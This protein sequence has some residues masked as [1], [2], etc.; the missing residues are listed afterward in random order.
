ML[1]TSAWRWWPTIPAAWFM[2]N[3]LR[4]L[5]KL[6][7]NLNKILCFYALMYKYQLHL[8]FRYAVLDYGTNY[9]NLRNIVDGA[10]W[11]VQ[12]GFGAKLSSNELHCQDLSRPRLHGDNLGQGVHAVLHAGLRQI[13]NCNRISTL[14]IINWIL[15]NCQLKV[16]NCF[17]SKFPVET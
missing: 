5:G 13:L 12:S 16:I 10:R 8:F 3:P 6:I 7:W 11:R 4:K 15:I 14:H 1:T 17:P 2:L 9:C